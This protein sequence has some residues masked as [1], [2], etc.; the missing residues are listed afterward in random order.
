VAALARGVE[1]FASI[2]RTDLDDS[3]LAQMLAPGTVATNKIHVVGT[4][5][6]ISALTKAGE[7]LAVNVLEMAKG[8]LAL[9][10]MQAKVAAAEAEVAQ[11]TAYLQQLGAM[12]DNLPRSAPTPQVLAA[13]PGLLAQFTGARGRVLQGQ[14]KVAAASRERVA[15]QRR[16]FLDGLEAA[17]AYQQQLMELNIAARRELGLPLD[18]A[19]YRGEMKKS[20]DRMKAMVETVVRELETE[21]G[22]A[23]P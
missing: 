16:L 15:L 18:E 2:G 4:D 19:K 8:R 6:T 11:S 3:Q 13:I 7:T 9:Q 5:A 17:L 22:V 21:R 14:A 1:Y 23:P 12:I 10:V 20:A